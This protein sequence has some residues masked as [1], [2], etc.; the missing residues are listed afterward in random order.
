MTTLNDIKFVSF[1]ADAVDIFLILSVEIIL[2][3]ALLMKKIA[4]L[5]D[6]LSLTVQ[7]V[8]CNNCIIKRSA[9][10]S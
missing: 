7:T 3:P 6:V 4:S 9:L 10:Y 2:H 5:N 1:T 8:K